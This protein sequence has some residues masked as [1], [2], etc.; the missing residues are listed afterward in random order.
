LYTEYKRDCK[1]EKGRPSHEADK[2]L[3]VEVINGAVCHAKGFDVIVSVIESSSMLKNPPFSTNC[4][5]VPKALCMIEF[6]KY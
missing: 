4:C 1:T 6:S 3:Y 5:H 2:R